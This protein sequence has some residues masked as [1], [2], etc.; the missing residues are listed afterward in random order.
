ME[1]TLITGVRRRMCSVVIGMLCVIFALILTQA[2][3]RG[4]QV[5]DCG[6]FG[7]GALAWWV[8]RS[9]KPGASSR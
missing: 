7:S 2:M 3:A 9:E 4:L 5:E 1:L 8:W 6:C